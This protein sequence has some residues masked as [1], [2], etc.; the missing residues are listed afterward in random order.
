MSFRKEAS[1]LIIYKEKEK[2]REKTSQ[3]IISK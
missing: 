1:M 3:M 2:G